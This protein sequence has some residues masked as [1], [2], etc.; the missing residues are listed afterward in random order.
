MYDMTYYNL[1]K[2][3]GLVVSRTY[4]LIKFGRRIMSKEFILSFNFSF[5]CMRII[6]NYKCESN[7]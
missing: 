2:V 4:C 7:R 3:K 6:I 5:M 1:R